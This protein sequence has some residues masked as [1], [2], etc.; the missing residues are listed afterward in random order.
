MSE[1]D[2]L[3]MRRLEELQKQ[4]QEQAQLREQVEQLEAAVKTMLNKEA[5]QRYGNIKAAYPEKAVQL[6]AVL[7]Q[8]IESGRIRE[9]L[10]DEELK[11]LLKQLTPKKKDISIR[12]V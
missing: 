10:N 2:V 7:G 1:L 11:Q 8:L 5:L 3:K 12:R 9:P 4:M 6:L